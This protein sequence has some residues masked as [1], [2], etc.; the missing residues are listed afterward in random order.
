MAKIKLPKTTFITTYSDVHPVTLKILGFS[1]KDATTMMGF[2]S[3]ETVRRLIRSGKLRT[4][5]CSER[6]K[7]IP[8]K[9]I[10]RFM[11]DLSIHPDQTPE[12]TEP[13]GV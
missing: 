5:P 9:E 6:R 2:K 1:V 10:E 11:G 3:Q 13:P 4:L 8:L 12:R 7:I